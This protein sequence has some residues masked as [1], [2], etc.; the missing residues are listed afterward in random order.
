MIMKKLLF[1]LASFASVGAMAQL[2]VNTSDAKV[3]FNYYSEKTTGTLSDVKATI[4]INTSD[5]AKST[6]SGEVP[7][8]TLDTKNGMRNKHLKSADYFD[9]EKYPTMYFKSSSITATEGGYKAVG[10]LKIKNVE[11]DVTFTMK[12]EGEKISL[13]AYIYA[14]DFGVAIKQGRDKSKVQVKII[15]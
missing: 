13:V 2:N 14:E 15:I 1:I 10:S 7:V 5:L 12:E 3:E 11:K 6:V 9:A 8:S 4:K